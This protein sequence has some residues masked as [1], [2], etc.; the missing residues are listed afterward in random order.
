MSE[1]RCAII[2]VGLGYGD[3][4]KGT[5]TDSL[6]RT[7]PV[8]TV[9]RFNGGAQAGHNVVTPDGR[10]HTF[11]QFGSGTF[12]R[13]VN[14][15]LARFMLL[16]PFRLLR[17][18]A[19]LQAL[20]VTDALARLSVDREALV[21]TPFQVAAN[22]LRELARGDGRHGSCGMGIG[23]TMADWLAHG[24]RTL[25]AGDLQSPE[26]VRRKLLTL[27]DL[28]YEQLREVLAALPDTEAVARERRIFTDPDTIET[29]VD[30]YAH[31]ARQVRLVAPSY[32]GELLDLPGT[33]LFEG[34]Q[35]VLLDE[36]QG[37]HPYT[38][39]S[40]T[41]F[42][43]A[44]TLLQ[45]QG[46]DGDIVKVGLLRAYMSRHGAG[47]FVTEDA[48]LR[49]HFTD[50]HNVTNDWQQ[51]FRVGSFDA[52][53]ARYAIE[54]AGQPDLLAVTHLDQLAQ[55]PERRLA[56]AYR[57]TGDD[58]EI[59]SCVDAEDGLIVRLR[60]SPVLEDLAYQERLTHILERAEP[61]YR[62][63]RGTPDDFLSEIECELGVP[64][65]LVSSGPGASDKHW[66]TP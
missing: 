9:V 60:L 13:G 66:R 55:A 54:A 31:V 44:L 29:C 36:W 45:E 14:T 3:E 38:T 1:D 30:V 41:T 11:A 50:P 12:V 43:N 61:V 56:V 47:P 18:D 57:Y 39:W 64:V 32:L 2:L 26:T 52:V 51:G 5:W 62:T 48:A 53:A 37:F 42:E 34:A 58:P 21:T 35:G 40:T 6:A 10:H 16:N 23:E 46:Y 28:K 7:E 63:V 25:V 22:R 8:H 65:R 27:R 33:V 20:G 17:E 4:G 24:D 59:G 15:H 19:A 49:S